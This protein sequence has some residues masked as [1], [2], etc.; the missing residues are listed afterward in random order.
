MVTGCA[1]Q[2]QAPNDLVHWENLY[3]TMVPVLGSL[4]F[5]WVQLLPGPPVT[6]N[7]MLYLASLQLLVVRSLTQA[8]SSLGETESGH[9]QVRW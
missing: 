5:S 4:G 7:S 9:T 2:Q 6:T 1:G 8:Q 3:V